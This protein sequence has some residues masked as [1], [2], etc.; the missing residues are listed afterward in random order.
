MKA[1]VLTGPG[2]LEMTER[3]IPACGDHEVLVR[4]V[5]YTH[6]DVYKRQEPRGVQNGDAAQPGFTQGSGKGVL[7]GDRQVLG[8]K[9]VHR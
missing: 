5:S 9:G 4:A 3:P 1:V 6:L 2:Q 8:V 7:L